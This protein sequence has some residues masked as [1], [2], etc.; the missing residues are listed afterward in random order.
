[1]NNNSNSVESTKVIVCMSLAMVVGATL[2]QL[3]PIYIGLLVEALVPTLGGDV[4][5]AINQAT[6]LLGTE[7]LIMALASIPS[8]FWMPRIS[9]RKVIMVSSIMVAACG[10]WSIMIRNN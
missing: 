6:S 10:V 5:A 7:L 1:M 2:T 9:W 8:F 3:P 4:P